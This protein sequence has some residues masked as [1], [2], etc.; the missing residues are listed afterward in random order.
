[1]KDIRSQ[2]FRRRNNMLSELAELVVDGMQ[3][4]GVPREKAV[5]V[6]EEIA[7]RLHR[8]WAGLTFVFPVK[9]ELAR[10]RLELH[11]LQRYDGSNADKLVQE[12]GISEGLIYEIVRKHRRQRKDDQMALFDP[13]E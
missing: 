11:I 9:D 4:C 8:R 13:A 12:F 10:R 1:M 5:S 2:Q 7:F 3:E 6:S